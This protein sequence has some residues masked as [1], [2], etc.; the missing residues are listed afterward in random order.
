M[1]LNG[2]ELP[3]DLE[4]DRGSL[5]SQQLVTIC[6]HCVGELIGQELGS[7]TVLDTKPAVGVSRIVEST[8]RLSLTTGSS[9]IRGQSLSSLGGQ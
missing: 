6:G 7:I 5:V 1:W 4:I 9:L 3:E 8:N 2:I